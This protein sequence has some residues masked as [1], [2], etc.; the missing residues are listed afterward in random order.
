VNLPGAFQGVTPGNGSLV[1]AF[2]LALYGGRKLIDVGIRLLLRRLRLNGYA[3]DDT[4]G[5]HKE[6]A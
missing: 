4:E 2:A 1:V 5:R 3:D 6:T